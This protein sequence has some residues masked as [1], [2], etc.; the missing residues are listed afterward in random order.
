MEKKIF[1]RPTITRLT[2]GMPSKHGVGT[3]VAPVQFID[4]LKVDDLLEKYGSPLYIF[5]ESV[6]R[7]NIQDL[8]QAFT[9]RYPK[10]QVAWSYKTNYL[11][12]ICRIFH[13]EGS[14]AEVVSGFEYEKARLNGVQG[15]HII[16]N[17]PG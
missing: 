9:V 5:S 13:Q 11:D 8:K 2:P 1:E 17:G 14:W 10:V 4:G 15:E 3:A 16:F 6:I 12:A 7:K